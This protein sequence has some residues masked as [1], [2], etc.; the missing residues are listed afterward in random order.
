MFGKL[1]GAT[2]ELEVWKDLLRDILQVTPGESD[3]KF[4]R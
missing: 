2:K 4:Q 3:F 1:H